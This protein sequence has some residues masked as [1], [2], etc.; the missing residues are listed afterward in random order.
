[1]KCFYHDD[2][3][4]RASAFC[5]GAWAG[6]TDG[7][8]DM[9][10]FYQ[11]INYGKAFPFDIIKPNEQI[12]IVDYSIEPEEMDRL[13]SIT[14]NVTWIDH[15]KTAIE[16]Y[17]GYKH[18][19]RGVRRDGEAGCVLTWKYI[20]W[21]TS[22][23]EGEIDLKK[24]KSNV[25]PVA[26]MIELVGD[27]DVW[28]WKFKETTR[29]FF[30]GSQLHDTGPDSDFWWKCMDH[31]T[32]IL[33]LPNTGNISAR[34][35]GIEFWN[36]LLL[37][38]ENIEKYKS[39]TDESISSTIGY[40][41]KFEGYDCF[42]CNRA[43]V[44]SDRFGNRDSEYDILLPH[45]HDGKQWTI[46]LYS[47]NIDVSEIAKKYGGGGHKGASGFQCKRLPWI[48]KQKGE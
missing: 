3:D 23:G 27:R 43:R 8:F 28:T 22:R 2:L 10:K 5:V 38:G 37:D 9:D 21:Y 12:W 32:P 35:K 11:S 45:Y 14:K 15:H 25:F 17:A 42:A 20:H 18:D 26:R 16:K 30:S 44:S 13:L 7:I 33:P 47:K 31:E 39:Q 48:N 24:N 19:I 36:Q 41:I 34:E 46:S 40:K 1:M 29:N 4:G 6:I